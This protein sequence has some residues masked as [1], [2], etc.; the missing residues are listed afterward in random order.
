MYRFRIISSRFSTVAVLLLLSLLLFCVHIS[1]VSA[2]PVFYDDFNDND[3]SDWDV[4]PTIFT[5]P[6]PEV[7]LAAKPPVQDGRIWGEGSGYSHPLYHWMAKPAEFNARYSLSVEICGRS[8]PAWPNR[9]TVYLMS[10]TWPDS[11]YVYGGSGQFNGKI[12][13]ARGTGLWFSIAGEEGV[14]ETISLATIYFD[15]GGV[16]HGEMLIDYFYDNEVYNDHM[17]RFDRNASG[18]WSLSIDGTSV[19]SGVYEDMANRDSTSFGHVAAMMYRSQSTIDYISVDASA[20]PE[21][22]TLS[23]LGLGLAGLAVARRKRR[24]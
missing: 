10:T 4:G 12:V 15:E 23:L 19:V 17:Y 11:G 8:G 5:P 2:V 7:Y 22:A 21:P 24:K 6:F 16:L 20:V 14:H 18:Y 3:I 9:A 13:D 1:S